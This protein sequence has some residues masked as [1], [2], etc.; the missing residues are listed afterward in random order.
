MSA[1]RTP[2][3][4]RQA[5]SRCKVHKRKC[6]KTLPQCSLCKRLCQVCRY[7]NA[8]S[9]ASPDA[10]NK[11]TPHRIKADIIQNLSDLELNLIISV[12]SRCIRPWFPFTS[13]FK[14]YNHLPPT[15]N[16]ASVD[17]TLLAF[18]IL[19]FKASP[20]LSEGCHSFN[21]DIMSMYLSS[22][23]WL[24]LLE[25]LGLNSI[26]LVNSRLL[27]TLFE[28][29]HGFYPAA[30]LSI[31]ATVRA[32]DA[33]SIYKSQDASLNRSSD[34]IGKEKDEVTELWAAI[35]I[36]DRYVAVENGKWPSITRGRAVP[37]CNYPFSGKNLERRLSPFLRL[38]EAS[39]HLDK[40]HMAV[41][42]PTIQ[43]SFNIEEVRLI[44]M[45]LKSFDTIVEHEIAGTSKLSSSGLALAST[46][47]FLIYENGNQT[48]YLD[49]ATSKCRA[50][51]VVALASMIEDIISL[52]K[53]PEEDT[54]IV[55]VETVSPFILHLVYKVAAIVTARLH[56]SLDLESNLQKVRS[57]RKI[58]KF[59]GQRWLAGERY[60][61]LLNEDT[62]PR[63]LQAIECG[64]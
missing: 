22:K 62:T 23:S 32:A 54:I 33:L 63:M 43:Q 17:F 20:Q 46:G 64:D 25:G 11:F 13:E 30:Y 8:A 14:L 56:S 28:V 4:T 18:I 49:E 53:G 3:T 51:S 19:L 55:D 60:L 9:I 1:R 45:T 40:V 2:G 26:D 34:L 29:V 39:S 15:W 42:E 21:S 61:R 12:Y 37:G 59:M 16:D 58:L 47:L 48:L 31:A 6:D 7:E 5:C 38:Y 10:E 41:H 57:C 35:M 36:V 52:F 27:I 44:L 50:Q 24:A